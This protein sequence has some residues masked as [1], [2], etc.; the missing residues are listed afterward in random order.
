MKS[1]NGTAIITGASS[2]L[3]SVWVRIS[4]ARA[5]MLRRLATASLIVGSLHGLAQETGIG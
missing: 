2:G 4:E 3:R 1:T 5:T